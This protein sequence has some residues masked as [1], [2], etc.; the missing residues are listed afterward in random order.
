MHFH[1]RGID[2][3][4]D[5][6]G[7]VYDHQVVSR[8]G[9][10]LAPHR[11]L[12]VLALVCTLIYSASYSAGP[13]LIGLA[14]DQFI[15][16][17]DLPGLTV[18]AAIFVANGL[19]SWATSYLQSLILASVGQGVLHRLRTAMFDHLQTL[20]LSFFDRNET[21][22][23]MSRV[24]NDVMAI[25]EL[26]TNGFFG[27]LQDVMSLV[28]VVYILFSM[29]LKLALVTM[30]VVPVLIGIMAVWQRL[31]RAAFMRV[32]RAIAAVNAGLQENISGVRVIQSLTR[33]ET[34]VRQFD[35][36]NAG[37][38]AANVQAG[39][40]SAAIQPVVELL[41]A[42]ATALVIVVGGDQ[43][44]RGELQVG[45]L[46]AFTLY[47]QRFFDPIRELTMQYAQFQRA[48]VG[49]VR[50][51]EILDTK[52]AVQDAPGAQELPRAAA[53]ARIDFEHVQFEY[54]PGQPVLRDF[55]LH[56]APGET[57]ALVGATGAGKSTALSLLARLY[58]VTGGRVMVDG[59]DVREVTQA[60]LRRQLGIV[61]QDP[62]LFSGTVRENIR[63]GRLDA[64][65]QDVRQA[66]EVVGAHSFIEVLPEGYDTQLQE[67]GGNLS[68]GQR[69]LI[70]FARALIANP[71]VLMLDEATANVDTQTE[72]TIQRALQR[73]LAGRTSI[74]I[75]HRLSTI[76]DADRII[77]MDE[78][79]I[80]E[81]GD[82]AQLLAQNGLYAGL[83]RMSFAAVGA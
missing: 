46:V 53:G 52:P 45:A 37:H 71:R 61:L 65:D 59:L 62:F 73:L 29:N 34:N 3:E 10:F 44:L 42:A 68:V 28:I 21:G 27:V 40:L 35:R 5:L 33:E 31:A 13:R 26:M 41:V 75:A 69:Q 72:L 22:R 38:F 2:D 51:F 83:H 6:L 57:V 24:Q 74:V 66:A 23:L 78:G 60:S 8:L 12:V 54:V 48:M 39:R 15:G 19:L 11:R 77:V 70:S 58:D 25:Q 55:D 81:Q 16:E 14:I 64:S 17:G 67:R 79:R 20:S 4:R 9:Q 56:I 36:T 18:I 80:V 47:V 49:G 30:T 50:I 76:R 32:R 7:S 1:G 82:H 43:V 63:Y